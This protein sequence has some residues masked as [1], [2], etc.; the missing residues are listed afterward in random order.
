[1]KRL[2]AAS[3]F[4]APL[5]AMAAPVNLLTNGSFESTTVSNGSYVILDSIA[6]WTV[7]PHGVELR[8]NVAGSAF[9][10]SNFAEL[11]TTT[12]SWISQTLNTVL[13]TAY[14]LTF[15]YAARPDNQGANSNGL[16][17][18]IG[19]LSGN[20]GQDTTTTWQTFTTTFTGTGSPMTLR[21]GATGR[22]D[23]YGT[24]LDNISV[25]SNA[26]AGGNAAAVPEPQSLALLLAGFG[27]MGLVIRRRQRAGKA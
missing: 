2:I 24:S 17:W 25:V 3:L 21:F 22:A 8:N 5:F 6:G 13:G 1:M 18:S 19:S 12:N 7:G 10:G 16:N 15:S 23:S 9:N 11:D 20:V 26:G 14:T 4:A 27:A